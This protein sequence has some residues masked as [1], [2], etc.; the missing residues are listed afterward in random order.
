MD[1][2][3]FVFVQDSSIP[4]KSNVASM[5]QKPYYWSGMVSGHLLQNSPK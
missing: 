3:V 5:N 4:S 2:M 1:T